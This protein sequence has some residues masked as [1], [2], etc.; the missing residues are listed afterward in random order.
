MKRIKW[1]DEMIALE[2][3]KY[4][5]R[6][7]FFKGCNSAYLL[8]KKRGIF[9][10]VC[11][12]MPKDIKSFQRPHNFKWTEPA[13]REEAKK[14]QGR[15]QFFM[16]ARGAYQSAK[17][18]NILDELFP[19]TQRNV[20]DL[21]KLQAKDNKKY[22]KRLIIYDLKYKAKTRG[23]QWE[24]TDIQAFE[25]ITSKCAYCD[26]TPDW[27]NTRVGIDRVDNN[28]DYNKDNCVPCCFIC[29]SA[30]G[31]RT[32]EEFKIWVEEV[33]NRICKEKIAA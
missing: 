28:K 25:L 13:V 27:P 4:K 31:S 21:F 17:E 12:H 30:K 18:L 33:Y 7:E 11:S 10:S 1:T 14:H 29:N 9:E 23:I 19:E 32:L 3:L 24:L 8:A 26:F 20:R 15:K 22:D 16:W 6:K 5:T 2:A